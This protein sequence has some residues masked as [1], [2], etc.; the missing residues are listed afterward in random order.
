MN[1]YHM[2]VHARA[3]MESKPVAVMD[4]TVTKTIKLGPKA[5]ATICQ[6]ETRYKYYFY[7]NTKHEELWL[8]IELWIFP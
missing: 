1:A 3:H 2:T 4:S 5:D 7:M 8:V 6:S